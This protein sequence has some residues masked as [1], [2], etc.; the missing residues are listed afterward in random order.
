M[1]SALTAI[2][3]VWG[4]FMVVGGGWATYAGHRDSDGEAGVGGYLV[5]GVIVL[6]GVIVLAIAATTL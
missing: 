2:L 5:G 6:L 3:V 1:A 4:G